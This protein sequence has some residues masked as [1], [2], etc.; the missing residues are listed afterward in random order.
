VSTLIGG[1]SA[2]TVT[3][4]SAVLGGSFDLGAGS[5]ALTLANQTNQISVANTETVQGGAGADTIV[6]TGSGTTTVIGGAGLNF[7]TGNTGA[8]QFVFDQNGAGNYSKVMNFNAAK[9]DR[10][11]LDTTGSSALSTN[12]YDLGGAA[13][14]DNVDIKAVANAAARL[15]TT[16]SNSGHGGFVYEQ[17]TG[18]LYYNATGNFSGGGTIVGIVTTNGT[19]PWT[20]NVSSFTQV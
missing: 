9:G 8:D 11:A 16:L 4:G 7:I 18:E 3:L 10:I 17:D 15:T 19:T 14:V 1:G 12:A 2:D 5:D 6:L 13:L 20:Y